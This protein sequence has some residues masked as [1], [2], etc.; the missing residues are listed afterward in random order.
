MIKF[1]HSLQYYHSEDSYSS[2]SHY[3]AIFYSFCILAVTN[4]CVMHT[5]NSF[6]SKKIIHLNKKRIYFYAKI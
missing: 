3:N 5:N 2:E 6:S 1:N 4:I